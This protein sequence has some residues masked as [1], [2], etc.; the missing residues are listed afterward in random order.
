LGV[1]A[2]TLTEAAGKG[3]AAFKDWS[4]HRDPAKRAWV[5]KGDRFHPV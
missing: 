5:Q 2:E 3:E 1:G 4:Q